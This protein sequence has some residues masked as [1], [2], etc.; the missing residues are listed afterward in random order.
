MDLGLE[1]KRAIVTGGNRGIG[2]CS[3]LAL[4]QEGARVCITARN[5]TLLDEVVGEIDAIGGEGHPV[6]VDLTALEG[7][8]KVVDETV[9]TFGG[10]DIL[11]NCA[12]VNS[13]TPYFELEEDD[14]DKVVDTN[15]K[16]VLF[17]SQA[18]AARMPEGGAIVNVSSLAGKRGS[19]NNSVYCVTKF[20]VNAV[21]QALAKELGPRK[22]RV[23][24]VCPVYVRTEG[25]T[26]ALT[27]KG[28]PPR[29]EDLTSYLAEFASNHTALGVLPTDDQVA[30]TCVFLASK[31]AAA[32]TGQCLNV[33]C[34]VLPQ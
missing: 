5:Q 2:R 20:G 32:I 17:G 30:A 27:E 14:W 23:N 24:A 1:G 25:L 12:G 13:A 26:E 11:V 3:S 9:G 22:I 19:A 15:L 29:G 31:A 21:T 33:D 28:A 10:V 18:V 16:S 4:A 34:G 8:Q 7:C 6:A